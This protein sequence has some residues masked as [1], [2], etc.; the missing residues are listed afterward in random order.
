MAAVRLLLLSFSGQSSTGQAKNTLGLFRRII[1]FF[2]IGTRIKLLHGVLF[3]AARFRFKP[4]A[5]FNCLN[6]LSGL[7]RLDG[8]HTLDTMLCRKVRGFGHNR[9]GNHWHCLILS[10]MFKSRTFRSTPFQ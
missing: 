10:L 5:F 4:I 6:C 3:I 2:G 1:I 7:N 8:L 9:Y